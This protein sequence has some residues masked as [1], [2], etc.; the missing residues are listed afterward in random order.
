MRTKRSSAV[1][2]ISVSRAGTLSGVSRRRSPAAA[3]RRSSTSP[4]LSRTSCRRGRARGS[5]ISPRSWAAVRRS[6]LLVPRRQHAG[7]R[8]GPG[9]AHGL[10]ARRRALAPAA[11]A[12]VPACPPPRRGSGRS[13][14]ARPPPSA[15]RWA[16]VRATRAGEARSSCGS[17]CGVAA[18]SPAAA[19]PASVDG[20]RPPRLGSGPRLERR[21]G[22]SQARRPLGRGAR[23]ADAQPRL[24]R[25]DLH[26]Q[27]AHHVVPILR[28]R[29]WSAAASG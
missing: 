9:V 20:G 28:R 11:S 24:Q 27:A 6:S 2:V 29:A 8:L 5:C 18:A 15:R 16:T 22:L 13:G 21:G 4:S 14:P 1:L 7:E 19:R 10:A 17:P 23:L 26:L 25:A 3:A 12:P